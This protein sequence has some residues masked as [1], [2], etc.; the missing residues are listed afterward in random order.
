[1]FSPDEIDKIKF[2]RTLYG[3]SPDRVDEFL[4]HIKTIMGELCRENESLRTS[5]GGARFESA[6]LRI[7]LER[8]TEENA[9][10][11]EQLAARAEDTVAAEPVEI[12][13]ETDGRYIAEQTDDADEGE[14]A[15]DTA[16][17]ED[18]EGNYAEETAETAEPE[19]VEGDYAE[20]S[21]EAVEVEDAEGDYTEETAEAADTEEVEAVSADGGETDDMSAP[22]DEY[23][24]DEIPTGGEA[25]AESDAEDAADDAE[26]GMFD[27][28]L[29]DIEEIGGLEDAEADRVLDFVEENAGKDDYDDAD[30]DGVGQGA[31]TSGSSGDITA[32]IYSDLQRIF[33]GLNGAGSDDAEESDEK[34][35]GSD[36]VP[37][38]SHIFRF[39][40]PSDEEGAAEESDQLEDGL[41]DTEPEEDGEPETVQR[42]EEEKP[43][44]Y[45]RKK[46]HIKKKPRT[47]KN[48]PDDGE[49]GQPDGGKESEEPDKHEPDDDG[50]GSDSEDD[51]IL[52]ALKSEYDTYHYFFGDGKK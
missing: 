41:H 16:E 42:T 35:D 26:D 44:Q 27:F 40:E 33:Y 32:D 24:E 46:Y 39:G 47:K 1:M 2:A 6:Q 36:A 15:A 19:D 43:S 9:R 45:K 37:D 49:G 4:A 38:F 3:Y 25:S 14:E 21:A 34:S 48:V 18:V 30:A 31:G 23:G 8:L 11:S 51:D 5:L 7:A 20:E 12:D 52:A 28:D 17:T 50:D 22:D 13:D 29:P 10:L